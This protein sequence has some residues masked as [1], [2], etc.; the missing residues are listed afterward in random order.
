YNEGFMTGLSIIIPT[1]NEAKSI[2]SLLDR[3]IAIC[4]KISD[5]F[6]ILVVD[7]KSEDSTPAIVSG[8]SPSLVKLLEKK[9]KKGKGQ[10]LIEGFAAAQYDYI[11]MIDADLQYPPE[12]FE[13]MFKKLDKGADIVIANRYELTVET[14]RK[15]MATLFRTLFGKWLHGF[16]HDV[17]SG[18]KVFKK[19]LYE[20]LQLNPSQWTFD[21]E[22]LVNARNAGAVI[23]SV[24]VAFQPRRFGKHKT[25]LLYASLQM[26]WQSLVLLSHY[27]RI[28]PFHPTEIEA[29][30]HG[31]HHR[32]KKYIHHTP[33][34]H[35][36]SAFTRLS[37]KQSLFMV[38]LLA[39]TGY[40]LLTSWRTSIL[41]LVAVL[42]V[43]YFVDLLFN[44]LLIVQSF[45]HSPEIKLDPKKVAALEDSDLPTYAILCPLYK[46]WQVIP[47]FVTSMDQ[48]EYP[49][50][51]LKVYLLL[52]EDDTETLQKVKEFTLPAHFE[53]L[54]VPDSFPK[55][56]PK[57]CNYALHRITADYVVIYDAEDVPEPDQ[58]KKVVLA[59]Q[60]TPKEVVCMQAKLNF[61]NPHQNLLTRV[62]TAEYSLWFDL[63][64]TGLQA[65]QAPIPLGGTSNHFKTQVL[66]DL[67]GWD[68]FNVTEDCDLGIRM[69]KRGLRTAIVDSI[70]NEE[71]NSDFFNWFSQ[72]SRWIK[73][74]I[75]T[76]LVHMRNPREFLH[77]WNEPHVLTFQLVVGGKVMSMFINPIMWAT[78]ILYFAFRATLGPIIEPF[79]PAAVFYMALT[80]LV[81]GNFLYMYYYMIGCA[82]R[83][84]DEIIKYVFLVPFYWLMMSVA[85]WKAVW[86]LIVA[87]HYWAKTK[88]GFHLDNEKALA[89]ASGVVGRSI[90]EYGVT[91]D[92]VVIPAVAGEFTDYVEP[93][94]R[95][96]KPMD[97]DEWVDLS[98]KNMGRNGLHTP[99]VL[100]EDDFELK[101]AVTSE[102]VPRFGHTIKK[103]SL[104]GSLDE[105]GVVVRRRLS[106]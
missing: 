36:E 90:T 45:I 24:D 43:L 100:A 82:K 14:H 47:Q 46:E 66:K 53:V 34:P 56:K 10:S 9:G 93:D 37:R 41:V 81:F 7:D 29:V 19:P 70:T 23:E 26:I 78:T 4:E 101:R 69:V 85:A 30:G 64:L 8:Y 33:L 84:H 55:T 91:Q 38:S 98:M 83:G 104:E 77:K 59:F 76:Y 13:K 74:Y 20:R 32:S 54:V 28:I 3:V 61:Y 48:I 31:F 22:F 25:N 18:M 12:G 40:F 49:K 72:R 65:I 16:S 57:A 86:S 50:N 52:E 79:F 71:A 106:I 88:H 6:E 15:I 11:G 51:K 73:G 105:D 1:L 58:L 27:R 87:P 35:A 102:V 94:T 2:K 96:P 80:C 103:V 42:T 62:F 97:A 21:L 75:Q 92:V 39:F 68:S 17:Q 67:Q 44:L 89:H 99:P 95:Y 5:R 60:K 63:V